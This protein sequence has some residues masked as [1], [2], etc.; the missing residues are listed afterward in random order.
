MR[1]QDAMVQGEEHSKPIAKLGM[2]LA[3]LPGI[4]R[5]STGSPQLWLE[6]WIYSMGTGKAL[7]HFRQW[8]VEA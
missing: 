3:C 6:V 2:S 5:K 1:K 7:R 4:P 8:G